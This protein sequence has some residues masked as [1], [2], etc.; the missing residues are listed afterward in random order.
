MSSFS[1]ITGLPAVEI[2]HVTSVEN[3]E[4]ILDKDATSHDDLLNA[5][6]LSLMFWH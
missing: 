5:F 6:R 4:G 1:H 2:D 3:G